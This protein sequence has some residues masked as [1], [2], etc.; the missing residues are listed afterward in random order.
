MHFETIYHQHKV[1]VYNLALHYVQNRHDAEEITQDV[2][3]AVHDH[4]ADFAHRS[5]IKTWLYRITINKSLDLIRAQAAQKR[6]FLSKMLRIDAPN[7]HFDVSHFDH[8]GVQ[9]EQRE[10]IERIFKAINTLTEQQKTAIILLRIEALAQ[11]EVAV[12]MQLQEGAVESLYQ[13]G[14]K[15]LQKILNETKEQKI[16][17]V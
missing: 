7:T 8:P 11:K 13:R 16:S 2:F 17:N 12:I 6:S 14:K 15:N 4:L 1:L 5:N 9:M 3:L 10:E